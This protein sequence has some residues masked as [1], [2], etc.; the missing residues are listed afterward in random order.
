HEIRVPQRPFP[1]RRVEHDIWHFGENRLAIRR[2][3]EQAE[4]LLQ[5]HPKHQLVTVGGDHT[6]SIGSVLALNATLRTKEQRMGLLWL[7]AHPDLNTPKT[8]PSGL[9]HGMA[10]A[11]ILGKCRELTGGKIDPC[12]YLSSAQVLLLGLQPNAF[13]TGETDMLRSQHIAYVDLTTILQDTEAWQDRVTDWLA[14]VD[15]LYI[16]SDL[17]AFSDEYSP[18]VNSGRGTGLSIDDF[19]AIAELLD[20]QIP[21][22]GFDIVEYNP[23]DSK[24]NRQRTLQTAKLVAK[25]LRDIGRERPHRE[26]SPLSAC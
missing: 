24:P 25:R 26:V 21:V 10:L 14:T 19:H 18:A 2:A 6:S 11:S 9:A 5:E 1:D 23:D 16:S 12:A 20:R 7:D 4:K 8:S 22:A 15:V 13:D 17:D 3:F